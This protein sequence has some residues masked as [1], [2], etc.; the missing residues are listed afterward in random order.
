MRITRLTI[1]MADKV[2]GE[3]KYCIGP[4]VMFAF[5]SLGSGIIKFSTDPSLPDAE[6]QRLLQK[7]MPEHVKKTKITQKLFIQ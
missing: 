3:L 5:C 6:C 1:F 4:G 7:Y 2:W